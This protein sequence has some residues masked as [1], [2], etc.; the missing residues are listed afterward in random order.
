MYNIV[1]A[2]PPAASL[3]DTSLAAAT[4]AMTEA[5]RVTAAAQMDR[6]RLEMAAEAASMR[7]AMERQVRMHATFRE[8]WNSAQRVEPMFLLPV[9]M[10]G[11]IQL[12]GAAA[13]D[14]LSPH[15]MQQAVIAVC[16]CCALSM[17]PTCRSCHRGAGLHAAS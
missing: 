3:G 8:G 2:G 14:R 6:L 15:C 16:G 11:D 1:S 13:R 9:T 4:A 10:L 17:G 5:A 12:K 7:A